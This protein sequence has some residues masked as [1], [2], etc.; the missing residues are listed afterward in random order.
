[1]IGSFYNHNRLLFRHLLK[2]MRG[3][4]NSR[5]GPTDITQEQEPLLHKWIPFSLEERIKMMKPFIAKLLQQ[6]HGFVDRNHVGL[7]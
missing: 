5:R 2:S 7:L 4:L 1:M 3:V 6:F